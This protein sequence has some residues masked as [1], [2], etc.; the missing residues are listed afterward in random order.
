M[1]LWG[2]S[3]HV[4]STQRAKP[5]TVII[6]AALLTGVGIAAYRYAEVWTPLQRRY[7]SLYV[8]SAVLFTISG[9]YELLQLEI[10]RAVGWPSRR[11]L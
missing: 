11:S 4:W 10:T 8:R 3:G 6:I 1:R 9:T 5:A 2:D 7:L